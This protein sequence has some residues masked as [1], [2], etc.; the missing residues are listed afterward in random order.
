MKIDIHLLGGA[1]L[2][3][4]S[5]PILAA[6]QLQLTLH[7][8]KTVYD[9]LLPRQRNHYRSVSVLNTAAVKL[10]VFLFEEECIGGEISKMSH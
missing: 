5:L 1:H 8:F 2:H 10:W 3:R 6:P 9:L 4:H 7:H